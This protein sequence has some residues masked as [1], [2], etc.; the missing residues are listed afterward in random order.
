MIT[1]ALLDELYAQLTADP[2]E[3]P[4]CPR[5]GMTCLAPFVYVSPTDPSWVKQSKEASNARTR[6]ALDSGNFL[7]TECASKP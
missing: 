7:C 5:C 2:V 1:Q 6:R 3:H 4:E